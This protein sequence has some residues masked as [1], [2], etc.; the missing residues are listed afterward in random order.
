MDSH[1]VVTGSLRRTAK[2]LLQLVLK[3]KPKEQA[4]GREGAPGR[5]NSHHES[6]GRENP[7]RPRTAR[8]S[9]EV[10]RD[11][12]LDFSSEA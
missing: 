8:G 9:G 5:R 4:A 11:V 2:A 1:W 3:L 6:A 7:V 10:S 12:T